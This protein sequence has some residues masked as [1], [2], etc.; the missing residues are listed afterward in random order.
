[1]VCLTIIPQFNNS[2]VGRKRRKGD[3]VVQ[4]GTRHEGAAILSWGR[5]GQF[6]EARGHPSKRGSKRSKEKLRSDALT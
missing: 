2:E 3:S 5:A 4:T 6:S 1:M